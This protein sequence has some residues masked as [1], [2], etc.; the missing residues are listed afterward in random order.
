MGTGCCTLPDERD[1][2]QNAPR[3]SMREYRAMKSKETQEALGRG[4]E[5]IT[6]HYHSLQDRDI[7][8][9]TLQTGDS[10]PDHTC[11]ESENQ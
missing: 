10:V 6:T 7:Y 5:G 9:S 3:S 8:A 1:V 11:C 4:V 2:D